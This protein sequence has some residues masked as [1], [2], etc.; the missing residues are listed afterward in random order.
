MPELD[1]SD[2]LDRRVVMIPA[3]DWAA[4]VSWLAR[5]AKKIPALVKLK[6]ITPSWEK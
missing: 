6:R 5:P 2:V 3:K 4:F 1:E